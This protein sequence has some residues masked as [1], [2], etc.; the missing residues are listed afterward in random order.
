MVILV[1]IIL[2]FASLGQC[3][4]LLLIH[5]RCFNLVLDAFIVESCQVI[6]SMHA[7]DVGVFSASQILSNI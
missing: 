7:L 3:F 5:L 6:L 4:V 1:A 2:C